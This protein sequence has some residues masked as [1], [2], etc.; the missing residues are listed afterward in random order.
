MSRLFL[1]VGMPGSGKTTF[2]RTLAARHGAIRLNPDDWLGP[3]HADPTD[4]TFRRHLERALW[5][6]GQELL[7]NGVAVIVEFG[8]WTRLERSYKRRDA[9]AL[10]VPVELHVL[11]VDLEERWRRLERRNA[12]PRAPQI[13]RAQLEE[14][15]HF[16]QPVNDEE[17][18]GFDQ[19]ASTPL[20]RS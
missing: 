6:H 1:V 20:G 8:S 7:R 3:L 15:E 19:P 12:S 17:R 2:A 11:D 4:A 13:T 18:S 14:W 16:W 10:G 9:Q 5:A